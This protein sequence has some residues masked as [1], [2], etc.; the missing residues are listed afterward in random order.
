LPQVPARR[1]SRASSC[2][3]SGTF[4]RHASRGLVAALPGRVSGSSALVGG[5]VGFRAVADVAPR[6]FAVAAIASAALTGLLGCGTTGLGGALGVVVPDRGR[7]HQ[8]D[9]R[10]PHGPCVK[11]RVASWQSACVRDTRGVR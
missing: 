9:R 6:R 3:T 2:P 7:R 4:A 10:R 1:M 11:P 8:L 5:L